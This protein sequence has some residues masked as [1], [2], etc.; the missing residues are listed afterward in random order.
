MCPSYN[1]NVTSSAAHQEQ[2]G[3]SKVICMGTEYLA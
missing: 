3:K 1:V 2:I